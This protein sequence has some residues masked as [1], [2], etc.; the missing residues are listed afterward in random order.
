MNNI[1]WEE[2]IENSIPLIKKAI[3]I[4]MLV[5][6]YTII[7]DLLE[8]KPEDKFIVVALR[9]SS[10]LYLFVL[11][12]LLEFN[13]ISLKKVRVYYFYVYSIF[14]VILITALSIGFITGRLTTF[15]FFAVIELELFY[16]TLII[17]RIK[18]FSFF[19]IFANLLYFLLVFLSNEIISFDGFSIFSSF[20][21]IAPL[22][23][24]IQYRILEHYKKEYFKRMKL[25][26]E[27]SKKEHA[28]IRLIEAKEIAEKANNAKSLFIANLSHEVRTPINGIF[29]YSKMGLDRIDK[30]SN[31]KIEHYFKQ[32]N[33][34][35]ERLL[36]LVNELLD[37]TKLESEAS[38]YNY[39]L[40]NIL[41]VIKKAIFEL[42]ILA[43]KKNIKIS[44]I[45]LEKQN[46]AYF[47]EDKIMQVVLNILGNAIKFSSEN[48]EIN[49]FIKH[50]NDG[51]ILV[52]IEDEGIGVEKPELRTIFNDF[53]QGSKTNKSH[54][55]TGLGLSI[56]KRIIMNHGGKIWAL[57]NK[58]NKRGL[59][60]SFT[61]PQNIT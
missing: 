19:I 50:Q 21:A 34:S 32:I 5:L 4:G 7:P 15:Y 48:S 22:S 9:V 37:F 57:N 41:T 36:K 11:V 20:V 58:E 59:T 13:K 30:L 3:Y 49:I 8:A 26:I 38:K 28:E 14:I 27:V 1:F 23:I 43:D 60:V 61:L 12:L 25:S 53:T 16:S 35:T 52:E 33:I 17:S 51:F 10:I 42:K 54:K 6:S 56:S 55:G 18:V 46:I 44:I 45:H 31:E 39:Q 29:N 47:D 24:Y 2:Y 40:N